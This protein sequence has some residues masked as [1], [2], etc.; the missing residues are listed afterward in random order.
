MKDSFPSNSLNSPESVDRRLNDPAE[1][2]K[3]LEYE[4]S[5]KGKCKSYLCLGELEWCC[6]KKEG[7]KGCHRD[8]NSDNF[9]PEYKIT[10]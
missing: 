3:Q 2:Q 6:D 8:S 1:K 5:R 4:Q 7:H 9:N 10:W